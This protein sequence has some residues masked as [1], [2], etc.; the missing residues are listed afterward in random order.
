M[1]ERDDGLR[2]ALQGAAPR[3]K[4]DGVRD[5]IERKRRAREVRRRVG[6][7]V[8]AIAVI[9]GS[10]GGFVGLR[11]M[12]ELDDPAR[13]P[14]TVAPVS[15]GSIAFT[16][17][18][19]KPGIFL[20]DPSSGSEERLTSGNDTHASWAPDGRR[21][22]FVR[23]DLPSIRL[24]IVD[25]ETAAVTA[26]TPIDMSVYR[27][28]WSPDGRWIA[29]DG[30][31][32]DPDGLE[33]PIPSG[34]YLVRPDGSQ[35]HRIT[36]DRFGNPDM[37]TWAPDGRSLIFTSNL[38]DGADG[39]LPG[40][41]VYRIERDGSGL[42]NLTNTPDPASSEL[43]IGW[44]R[45]G[46]ILIAVSPDVVRSGEGPDS[47]AGAWLE[48]TPNGELVRTILEHEVNSSGRLQEPSLS[49]DRRSVV[50]DSAP[51][52]GQQNIWTI[53]LT[54]LVRQQVTTDG[55]FLGA[56]QP[57][58]V[59]SSSTSEP[60]TTSKGDP[61]P[62]EAIA[63]RG[64]RFAVCRPMSI[65]GE[66]GSGLDT[67]WVFER[68]REPGA[69]CEHS[70]GFHFVGVGTAD[71]VA[72]FTGPLIDRVLDSVPVWPYTTPDIDMDGV[73]EIMVGTD[74]GGSDFPYASVLLFR[75]GPLPGFSDRVGIEPIT[76]ECEPDCEPAAW[77][78]MRL[79]PGAANGADCGAREGE[80]GLIRWSFRPSTETLVRVVWKLDRRV[81]RAA[82][83]ETTTPAPAQLPP[84]G[85][86][87]LCGEHVFW[88]HD[89]PN[90]PE[91]SVV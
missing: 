42:V 75:T 37:P 50:Y 85:L 59:L 14:Q 6:S 34:I 32:G 89:F 43:P 12:F 58:P 72:G 26:I 67:L 62:D 19:A 83:E 68:E 11:R 10:V 24:H 17:S 40:W 7:G 64:V 81:L 30:F 57:I 18:G 25:L 36:D 22:V 38:K 45:N 73:D 35:L 3:P 52:G 53:D 28:A 55:G 60:S 84:S 86:D 71:R 54:T 61:E 20:V 47:Q 87:V 56:W 8:L 2:R 51:D 77:M 66:F 91:P 23:R 82:L 1:F 29:F 33:E 39:Y 15:N 74:H 90:Y 76:F 63:L 27:P 9:A 70:E 31:G 16:K 4:I 69:G 13:T 80:R 21:L 49:P 41:D 46:N 78:S 44:L 88:P 65:P 48:I 5:A 79:G